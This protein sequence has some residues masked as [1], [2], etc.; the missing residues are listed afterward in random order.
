VTVFD[1]GD[2]GSILGPYRQN[3]DMAK[4]VSEKLVFLL[5]V[6]IPPLQALWKLQCQYTQFIFSYQQS[7]LTQVAWYRG[8]LTKRPSKLC[9]L[10]LYLCILT[11]MYV[12]FRIF[13]FHRAN[14]HS[15][16]TLT[17]VYPCFFLSCKTNARV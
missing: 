12:L 6:I 11:F 7:M 2:L 3:D 9:V 16:A 5:P 8:F 17:E 14:W 4:S 13:S 10:L 15:P 1:R